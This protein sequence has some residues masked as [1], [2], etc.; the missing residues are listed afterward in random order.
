MIHAAP[1]ESYDIT[2][3][4]FFYLVETIPHWCTERIAWL[5]WFTSRQRPTFNFQNED[6]S[7]V[8]SDMIKL[9]ADHPAELKVFDEWPAIH[10]PHSSEIQYESEV[11]DATPEMSVY[12]IIKIPG[13]DT[14]LMLVKL[15][16][17]ALYPPFTPADQFQLAE[18]MIPNYKGEPT[19]TDVGK[20]FM[21]YLLLVDPFEKRGSAPIP[22]INS[23]MSPGDV[24]DAY[25]KLIL[26]DK[27]TR[28]E[29][30]AY[31]RNAYSFGEDGSLCL[32]AWS[33]KS[34]TTDPAIRKK[35][36]ELFAKYKDSLNDP[37]TVAKIEE[38]LI[39]LDKEFI[40]GDDSEAFYMYDPGKTFGDQRKKFFFTFG[41]SPA[42]NKNPGEYVFTPSSLEEG[43]QIDD[44]PNAANDI[45][46]GSYGRGK[47]TAK[48]G[49]QTK[50]VM[51]TFQHVKIEEDDCKSTIGLKVLLTKENYKQWNGRYLVGGDEPL[52]NDWCKA[53][54]GEV[55]E[56]RSPMFCKTSPGYCAKCCGTGIEK[57]GIEAI[58]LQALA[59]TS[60]FTSVSMKA[61]HSSKITPYVLKNFKKFL[62]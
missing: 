27:C 22:Y 20:F 46:R 55:I 51:R 31:M 5:D 40:K 34:M 60:G 49:V 21:N 58:G 36:E 47:E 14:A 7:Y 33:E 17:N 29:F 30:N 39:A 54:I 23:K 19:I 43:W 24:D 57:L 28:A 50:F 1:F 53:H 44:I 2:N 41:V 38:E 37:A 52:T 42:F 61:M 12:G 48:G 3:A 45:R 18:G 62:R 59:I 6:G 56:I 35:K 25:A 9:Q 32:S 13:N 8:T 16:D 26:E 10:I 4:K 11:T 15:I